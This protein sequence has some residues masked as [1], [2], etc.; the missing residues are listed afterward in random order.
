MLVGT[1]EKR[2]ELDIGVQWVEFLFRV[3]LGW[4]GGSVVQG[5]VHN[6]K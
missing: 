5:E 2:L 3:T 6:Q 4:R 1:G